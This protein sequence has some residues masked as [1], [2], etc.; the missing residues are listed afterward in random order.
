MGKAYLAL[1]D[2]QTTN[3]TYLK[4]IRTYTGEV[5][6]LL[7]N[8]DYV[9][10]AGYPKIAN[11]NASTALPTLFAVTL[12]SNLVRIV[13]VPAGTVYIAQGAAAS[14]ATSKLPTGG[15]SLPCTKTVA[16]DFRLFAAAVNCDLYVLI[17]R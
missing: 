5:S 7:T 2:T 8:N 6:D 1:E 13:L 15:I 4:Y 3:K 17:P 16:D 11:V 14:A 12:P 10:A 9:V